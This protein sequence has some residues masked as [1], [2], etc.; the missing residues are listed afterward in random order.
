MV[1]II[2]TIDPQKVFDALAAQLGCTATLVP[3]FKENAD[4][5]DGNEE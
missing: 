5:T 1:T 4:G 2:G 3:K